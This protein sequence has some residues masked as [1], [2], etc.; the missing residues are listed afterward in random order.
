L[1]VDGFFFAAR[2]PDRATAADTVRRSATQLT[3]SPA[4]ITF[5]DEWDRKQ[6]LVSASGRDVTATARFESSSTAIVDVDDRGLL[7][8]R[9]QGLVP[10][11]KEPE[12][13]NRPNTVVTLPSLPVTL[14]IVAAPAK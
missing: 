4:N 9:S 8:P 12:A 10:L 11:N 5:H 1:S 14:K 2:P 7:T 6:V 13:N 3:V